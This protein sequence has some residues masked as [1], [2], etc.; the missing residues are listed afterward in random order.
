MTKILPKNCS[1]DDYCLELRKIQM[2]ESA[3]FQIVFGVSLHRYWN[4]L[5][6]FDIVEFDQEVILSGNRAPYDVL[7]E[8][9]GDE[10]DNIICRLLDTPVF[11]KE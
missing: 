2:A 1:T 3:E 10:A 8:K 6:G 9:F 4:N 5:T 7:I 11:E